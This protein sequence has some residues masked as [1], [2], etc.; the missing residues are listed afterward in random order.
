MSSAGFLCVDTGNHFG[1]AVFERCLS[2]ERALN[3]GE[4]VDNKIPAASAAV[5]VTYVLARHSLGDDLR[6]LVDENFGF[7]ACCIDGALRGHSERAPGCVRSF[8]SSNHLLKHF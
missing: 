8:D 3:V 4:H 5:G 6:M 1:A 2:V 7:G